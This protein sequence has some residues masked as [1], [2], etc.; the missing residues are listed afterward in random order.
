MKDIVDVPDIFVPE[1]NDDVLIAFETNHQIL[2]SFLNGKDIP[3]WQFEE[4]I[5]NH[6]QKL[7]AQME[8]M[9]LLLPLRTDNYYELRFTPFYFDISNPRHTPYLRVD[10]AFYHAKEKKGAVTTMEFFKI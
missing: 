9:S 2:V 3:I 1:T 4:I 10:V 5:K 6:F 8:S 7:M